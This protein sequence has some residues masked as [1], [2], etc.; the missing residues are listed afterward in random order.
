MQVERLWRSIPAQLA[1]TQ[2][3][4]APKFRFKEVI[5][6]GGRFSKLIGGIDWLNTAGLILRTYIINRGE[7]PFSAYQSENNF[8]LYLFDSGI[9]GALSHLP[10]S[11]FGIILMALIKD[12]NY[13]LGGKV[14]RRSNL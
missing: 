13:S 6:Q 8:K 4:S 14:P 9:L 2:D 5:S 10:P 12:R 7:L 3:G 11:L 1:K